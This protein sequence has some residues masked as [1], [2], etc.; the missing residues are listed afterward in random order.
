MHG[1]F[2]HRDFSLDEGRVT[3]VFDWDIAGPGE[4]R[5]DLVNLAFDVSDVPEDL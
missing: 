5:F 1:D 3:G 2:H 4:W